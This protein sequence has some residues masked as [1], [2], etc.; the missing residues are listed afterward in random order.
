MARLLGIDA[1]KTTVRVALLHTSYRSIEIEA[2]GEADVAASGSEVEAI[3]A[4]VGALRADATAIS[5]S[6]ER[7]FYRRIDLPA[8]A[9]K[10]LGS[11]LAFELESTVPFEMDEAVFDFRTMKRGP[12]DAPDIVPVFAVLA[13]ADDVRERIAPVREALGVEPE[14]VASGPLPLANLTQVMPELER[15]AVPGPIAVLDLSESCSEVL[16]LLAGEPVF[17]RTLSR[18]TIGLPESAPALARELRQTFSAWRSLGGDPLT[19]MYLTG[20][21]AA[22]AGAALFL[23]TELGVSIL[24]L[25]QMRVERLT[26]E[27]SERLP[28]FAKA[29]SLALG[30]TGRTRGMNLRRGSL[31]AERSYPF[32]RE[33]IPLLAGLGAVILVSFGFSVIA[34]LRTLDTEHEMLGA[35]LTAASRDVLGEETTDPDKAR[36]LLEQGPG[37]NDEDPMPHVDAFDAMVA[38]SKSVPPDI[39]HD[40]VELDASRGHVIIQGT[41]PTVGDAENISKA[42]KDANKCFKDV[43]IARTSQFTEG[44]Q[45]YVLELDLKCE[46]KKKPADAAAAGS[47][48]AAASAKPEKEGAR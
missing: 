27:Q 41:V 13:R 4:A 48:Q 3:R 9:Q 37:K 36:E 29:V 40:V 47:A 19:G 18:G 45:K 12:N 21:G 2:L 7:S 16:I 42:M 10:E 20:V 30:L 44:K 38:L 8:A 23:S 26:P 15:P 6:G 28:R 43:K 32:L 1:T 11:V 14:R 17:A 24:P 34:E 5:I 46:E 31:E 33:K 39:V 22:S 35:R 25:P